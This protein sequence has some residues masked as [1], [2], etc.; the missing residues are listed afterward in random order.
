MFQRQFP[1][2]D[3]PQLACRPVVRPA[4]AALPLLERR[5]Q[6]ELAPKRRGEH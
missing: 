1:T 3:N 2:G 5:L 6:A 4:W